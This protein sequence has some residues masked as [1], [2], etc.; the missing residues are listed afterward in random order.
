MQDPARLLCR[1]SDGAATGFLYT[2]IIPPVN[3]IFSF[4]DA[5][6]L[7]PIVEKTQG[8]AKAKD[9]LKTTR[10]CVGETGR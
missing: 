7:M 2:P 5:F 6:S 9:F 8:C 10:V 1:T 3:G 4:S